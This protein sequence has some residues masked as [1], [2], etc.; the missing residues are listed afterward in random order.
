M[1]RA[2]RNWE[3]PPPV[4]EAIWRGMRYSKR[5]TFEELA[6]VSGQSLESVKKYVLFLLR[7]KYLRLEHRANT[8]RPGDFNQ[9]LL[10]KETGPLPPMPRNKGVLYDP[11]NHKE[12]AFEVE[13]NARERAWN[14]MREVREFCVP[15]LI[16]AVGIQQK[17]AQK[18]CKGLLDAGFL[19]SVWDSPSG[20]KG[21]FSIY[22]LVKDPGPLA[23]VLNR[24]GTVSDPNREVSDAD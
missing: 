8:T 4:R 22:R 10:L 17:N 2:A 24:D 1:G 19:I 5:F 18:Y 21:K 14:Y 6:Q 9:Y 3:T 20:E 7:A 15:A 11:N 12:V 13:P 16:E 23:L